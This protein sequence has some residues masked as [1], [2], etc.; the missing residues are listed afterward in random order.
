MRCA[1]CGLC[2]LTGWGD[3]CQGSQLTPPAN[4]SPGLC[5]ANASSCADV[6]VSCVTEARGERSASAAKGPLGGVGREAGRGS[7]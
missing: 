5:P 4:Q 1:A 3:P 2:V 7:L 6:P